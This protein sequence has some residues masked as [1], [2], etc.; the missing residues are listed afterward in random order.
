VLDILGG[1]VDGQLGVARYL[2]EGGEE[3]GRGVDGVLEVGGGAPALRGALLEDPDRVTVA[4][5]QVVQ[6]GFLERG[7]QGDGDRLSRQ[8]V[9]G[10]DAAMV[11]AMAAWS[12][13]S[14]RAC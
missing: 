1:L 12:V 6:L 11:A 8:L 9:P 14:V 5:V 10:R 2:G 7:G 4:V 3:L 13:S